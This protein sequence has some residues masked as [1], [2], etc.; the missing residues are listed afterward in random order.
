MYVCTRQDV[1]GF[2]LIYWPTMTSWGSNRHCD[3]RAAVIIVDDAA[4]VAVDAELISLLRR[5]HRIICAGFEVASDPD[6]YRMG[7]CRRRHLLAEL[8]RAL[9]RHF[10]SGGAP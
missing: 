5:V 10:S 2:R 6:S 9:G 3:E 4:P 8:A 1:D 7:L